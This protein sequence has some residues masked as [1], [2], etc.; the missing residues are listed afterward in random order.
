MTII[1]FWARDVRLPRIS[2]YPLVD[3][4]FRTTDATGV[5]PATTPTVMSP[6]PST[7]TSIQAHDIF[8]TTGAA[9]A[10]AAAIRAAARGRRL[11]FRE[12]INAAIK[13]APRLRGLF[14]GKKGSQGV[15]AGQSPVVGTGTT[16]MTSKTA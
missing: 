2:G 11:K 8:A 15:A 12:D 6:V 9:R 1:Y 13:L 3:F 16:S 14:G 5:T 10:N 4:A 7:P